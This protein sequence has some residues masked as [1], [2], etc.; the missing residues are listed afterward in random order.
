M[1]ALAGGLVNK[2]GCKRGL[3]GAGNTQFLDLGD[4]FTVCLAYEIYLN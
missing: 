2:K 1:V 3:Q 4:G